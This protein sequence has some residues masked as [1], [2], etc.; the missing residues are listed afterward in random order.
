MGEVPGFDDAAVRAF[1]AYP[2]SLAFSRVLAQLDDT[3]R[4]SDP[5]KVDVGAVLKKS[6]AFRAVALQ[7]LE[8]LSG[9]AA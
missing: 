9:A 1:A 4:G 2:A 3:V 5:A 6:A 8:S 7:A